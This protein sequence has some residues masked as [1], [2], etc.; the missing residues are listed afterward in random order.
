MSEYEKDE[1]NFHIFLES[2]RRI[3]KVKLEQACEGLCSASMIKR[4]ECGERLPEKQIR[5]RILERMGVPLEGYEDYLTAEEYGQW[6]VRESICECIE[7]KDFRRAAEELER[8]RSSIPQNSVGIQFCSAMEYLIMQ[9]EDAAPEKQRE[10]IGRA[11]KATV[12]RIDSGLSQDMLLSA[13]ELDL[14]TEY[15]RLRRY[16]GEAEN[17]PVWRY[18][19]YRELLDYVM[20]SHL[21]D[22]CRAKVYPKAVYYLCEL[23]WQK[24]RTEGYLRQAAEACSESVRLLR[25]SGRLYYFIELSEVHERLLEELQIQTEEAKEMKEWHDVLLG[26]YIENN[27]CPYMEDFCYLYRGME[28]Y[29]IND[30]IRIRRNMYG[31]TREELCEGICSVRTL[32]RIEQKKAKTQMKIVRKLFERLGLCAEYI[33]AR[34]VTSDYE[35]IQLATE[36]SQYSN[37]YRLDEWVQGL[38]ELES[39]LSMEIP[40]NRQFI[41][42]NKYCLKLYKNEI[43]ME[44]YIRGIFEVLRYT[45]PI[46]S[47]MKAGEKFLTIEEYQIIRSA[48]MRGKKEEEESC[49]AVVKELCMQIDRISSY[50]R[51][52]EFLMT[53]M[54]SYLGNTGSYDES[55]RLSSK[56]LKINLIRK[57]SHVLAETI[58]NNWWNRQERIGTANEN[59]KKIIQDCIVLSKYN[60]QEN[61]I[62]FFENVL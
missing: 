39:K 14:Y 23:V 28:S 44:E 1:V 60:R 37:D 21:D 47:V 25:E 26:L 4:I 52:Y 58:Y 27:V 15:I 36:V 59:D 34:V 7:R 43:S 5:D 51:K 32:L 29:C 42:Y 12:P 31:M 50:I 41:E 62:K 54:I 19:K 48:G 16:N 2:M 56:L 8:Y 35:T 33:R 6:A 55:D 3:H 22:F 24:L 49:M 40:Q 57:R 17:E 11:I 10:V 9:R 18:E 30:V 38:K 53:S 13:Q 20:H 46:Q 61:L 45:I